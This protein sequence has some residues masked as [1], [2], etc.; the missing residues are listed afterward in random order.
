MHLMNLF[1]QRQIKNNALY[2]SALSGDKQNFIEHIDAI[3]SK[4]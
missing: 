3:S 1:G 4:R 2:L